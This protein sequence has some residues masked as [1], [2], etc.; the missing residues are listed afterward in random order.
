[1]NSSELNEA[2]RSGLGPDLSRK[3]S[4]DD[5]WRFA[6]EAYRDFVRF[7]DGIPDFTS[8]A[9]SVDLI[10]GESVADLSPLILRISRMTRRS[11]QGDVKIINHTDVDKMFDDDYG[12]PKT[13]FFDDTQGEVKYAVLGMEKNKVRW[14]YVPEVYD[15][16]DM[17]IHRLPVTKITKDGQSLD[18]VEEQHHYA[19][20]DRMNQLAASTPMIG[21]AA[22]AAA[23]G[24]SFYEYCERVKSEM[25]R[26]KH[27][28][29]VV[30]YGGL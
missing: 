2:F 8:D 4:D 15:V 13:L 21:N 17:V 6:N 12:R 18:E 28:T 10:P 7:T 30:S 27:K 25:N 9:T 26:Y 24:R 29:R 16:V 23:Y 11:D 1:M 5:V 19:L 3:F 20:L 14:V 22:G